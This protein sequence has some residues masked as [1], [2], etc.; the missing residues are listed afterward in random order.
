M[1]RPSAVNIYVEMWVMADY[2]VHLV[3]AGKKLKQ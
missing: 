2:N 1:R 3:S